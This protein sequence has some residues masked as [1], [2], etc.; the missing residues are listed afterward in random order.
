MRTEIRKIFPLA[1]L[2]IV[3]I[4]VSPLAYAST[5]TV[6]LNPKTGLAT[7]DSVSTTKI[8]FTYPA[9]SPVST[10]LRNVS[11][12]LSLSGKFDG[13]AEG[14]R[15]LQGSFED[16]DSHVMVSNISVAVNFVAK[17]NSTTL[18]V[19]K[20]TKVNATVSGVFSV[21]NGTVTANLGW[22]AFIVRG[23]MNLPL[24]GRDVDVN[25]AGSAMEDSISS[26][27][28]A[29]GWLVNA[30]GGGSFWNRPTLNFTALST[31]LSTWTKNYNAATNTTTFSKTI[32]GQ[33]TFSVKATYN[34]QTYS[35]SAVSDPSGVVAVQGYAN[36]SGDSLAITSAPA[37]ASTGIM[38]A[39]VIAGLLLVAGAYI[40]LR[41]KARPRT[42]T[43]TPAMASV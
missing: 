30:F 43:T 29:A 3:L 36:A 7:V 20:T 25:L 35:F 8:V 5:L 22:R 17:G 39:A 42:S 1:T 24:E 37:S 26:H 34:G 13:S 19:D 27:A 40:A 9:S 15:E 6:N 33:D 2:A 21:V 32:S 38:V 18:V 10:Y 14:A 41:L 16:W 11:S 12:S 28:Y 31:P 4:S 23:A